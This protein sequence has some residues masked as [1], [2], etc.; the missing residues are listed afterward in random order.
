MPLRGPDREPADVVGDLHERRGE[1][2]QRAVRV[3]H[4]RRSSA[5]ASNL[6]GAVTNGSPVSRAS[7]AATF[8]A[9]SRMRV[10]AGADRGAAERQLAQV[11][12]RGVDVR[13]PVVELRDVAGELL[14]QRERRR[15]LQVGAADL[16]DVRELAAPCASSVSRSFFTAGF[17]VALERDHR[18]DVHRG[19]KRVVRRL[20]LV[21]V[22]VRVHEALLAALAAEQLG[23]AVARAP[24]SRSCWSACRSRSA[25]R[26][27][28]TDRRACRRAPRRR[29]A[30]I[31]S[32]FFSSSTPSAMLTAAAA[33]F[34]STCA[35]TTSSGMVS[36]GKWKCWRLR[37]GLRAPQP[38]GGD[39]DVAHRVALDAYFLA[40][41]SLVN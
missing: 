23:G 25:T 20:P 19:G 3:H 2:L 6:L 30:M 9:N 27:A 41:C 17:S 32:P 31:A 28:G 39:L 4:A 34:T 36:P 15:V 21:D 14:A 1:R 37:C 29:P 40:S 11:R 18:G 10:E 35:R 7:S 13:E 24:R 5:S 12:Q 16:D 22:V 26:P 8:T 38:V 33:F